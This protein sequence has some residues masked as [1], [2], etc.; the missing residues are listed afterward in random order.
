MKTTL[1]CLSLM[2]GMLGGQVPSSDRDG[3]IEA[4]LEKRVE[5]NIV[6]KCDGLSW[7]LVMGRS[8][9]GFIVFRSQA[10]IC[11]PTGLDYENVIR[12]LE[13][14]HNDEKTAPKD[15]ESPV[16][17]VELFSDGKPEIF[18]TF[19]RGAVARYFIDIA[20]VQY[21]DQGGAEAFFAKYG[22]PSCIKDADFQ[23]RKKPVVPPPSGSLPPARNGLEGR[24]DQRSN[25]LEQ[26][27]DTR[28]DAERVAEHKK[29]GP[30]N[31]DTS[32]AAATSRD[33]WWF[34]GFLAACAALVTAVW[35]FLRKKDL[36][37]RPGG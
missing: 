14:V 33:S 2:A 1:V 10:T 8:G 25:V 19:N 31:A 28:R 22:R 36:I 5:D 13:L 17:Y 26:A 30:S 15:A 37:A 3:P 21:A 23:N 32:S 27:R 6:I 34:A 7:K 12:N 29:R 9:R 11:G 24:P 18:K 4:L 20:D 16:A 35:Y